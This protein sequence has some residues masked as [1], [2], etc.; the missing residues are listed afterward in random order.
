MWA[1]GSARL[2]EQKV[3]LGEWE[4][5][6]RLAGEDLPVRGH[7][8]GL[9]VDHHLGRCAVQPHVLLAH[10]AALLHSLHAL[11]QPVLLPHIRGGGARADKGDA[12]GAGGRGAEGREH[13]PVD[14]GLGRGDAA[15]GVAHLSIRDGAAL[16][17]LLRLGPEKCGPPQAQVRQLADLHGA[18]QVRHA[19]RDGGIN[20]VLSDEALDAEVV[21]GLL[22]SRRGEGAPLC[23]HL[24]C[25]L[26][27]ACDDLP[28]TA[29]RLAVRGDDGDGAHVVQNV[30]RHDGL[31]ADAG[32]RKR[33]VLRDAL[34]QVVAV[35][36]HVQVLV[37]GV[38]GVGSGGVGGAWDH[39]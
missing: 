31:G 6:G 21:R 33:H 37:D 27:G 35:D 23:L 12:D 32:L 2:L 19:V 11:A 9:G 38:F 13:G 39:V 16:D 3:A 28:H 5:G 26:P 20:G 36:Q 22:A 17:H 15:V 1:S 34:V 30:L 25:G 7:H 14:E 18:N 4:L 10:R 29:H 8:I 24:M